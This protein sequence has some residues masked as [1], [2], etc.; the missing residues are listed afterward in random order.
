[1]PIENGMAAI[2]Q[3]LAL[4]YAQPSTAHIASSAEITSF[5]GEYGFFNKRLPVWRVALDDAAQTRVFVEP[6]SGALALRADASD[7][8]EGWSFIT[9]HKWH[10]IP[11][12][13]NVRDALL[14]LFALGNLLVAGMGLVLFIRRF[15][16]EKPIKSA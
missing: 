1:M 9:L 8:R 11:W 10:F 4:H 13:A 16:K 7:A 14:A 12:G 6:A 5:N 2:A 15:F 3:T